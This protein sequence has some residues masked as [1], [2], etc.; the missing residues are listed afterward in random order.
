MS[1]EQPKLVTS[2]FVHGS[3]TRST[4]FQITNCLLSGHGQG[5]VMHYKISHPPKYLWNDM[6]SNFVCLQVI[7]LRRPSRDVKSSSQPQ[8]RGPKNWPRSRDYWPRPHD[9]RGPGLVHLGLVVFEVLLKCF[10]MLTLD[11]IFYLVCRHRS[12]S[13]HAAA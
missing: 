5:H 9:S 8:P 2:N 4:N 1:L 13:L 12:S 11:G 10:V 3:A 7:A 6:P